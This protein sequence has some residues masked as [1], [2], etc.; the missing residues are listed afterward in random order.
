[1]R[2]GQDVR[3]DAA[4]AHATE[5]LIANG[6]GGSAS[7]TSSG[8]ATRRT[9][10][11]LIS[12][13]EHGRQTTLL[14]ALDERLIDARGAWDLAPG[15]PAPAGAAAHAA[16]RG[17]IEHFT[18]D[19]APTWRLRAGDVVLEKRIQVIHDHHAVIVSYRHLAGGEARLTLGP[20]VV[21]RR[22]S[23]LQREDHEVRGAAQGVPGRVKIEMRP[24]DPTLTLWHNGTFLP[25]RLWRRGLSYPLDPELGKIAAGRAEPLERSEGEPVG[26]ARG[27]RK[28]TSARARRAG[29]G[30]PAQALPERDDARL[31][32]EDAL[33]PGW[34]DGTL[35]PGSPL[36]VVASSEEDLFRRLAAE[37]RLGTPPPRSLAECVAMIE[38][39]NV[40]REDGL[41]LTI[42]AG[43]DFTARQAASAHN[44]PLARR[45]DALVSPADRWAPSL[46]RA[47]DHALTRHAQHRTLI[48]ALP[49]PSPDAG[50]PLRALP[51]LVT[52]RRFDE[53]RDVLG[54]AIDYLDEGLAPEGFDPQDGTPRHADPEPAL[55]LVAAA[56]VYVRRSNDLE[57]LGGALYP[58][59]ES[60]MQFYRSGTR[61]VRVGET[62][63]L[64]IEP[65]GPAVA[66]ADLNA[67]WYHALV[68]MAQLARL[69]SRKESGAFYL[70]WAR[71]LRQRF[72]EQFW[73]ESNGRLFDRLENGAPVSGIR[74]PHVLAASLHP[75]VI[76]PERARSLV[77]ALERDLFT[78][79]GLRERPRGDRV[80]TS[81]LGPYYSA[82]VRAHG[83]DPA[84]LSRVHDWLEMLRDALGEPRFA[85]VPA[86][87]RLSAMLPA[88]PDGIYST[89]A[90]GELLRAWIEEL[91]PSAAPAVREEPAATPA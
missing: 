41:A 65:D 20:C 45:R 7:G 34:I 4:S 12:A 75:L 42:V 21:C 3:A 82:Y 33:V 53:T 1:M 11:L 13:S 46:G 38:R 91:D 85:G 73:D 28:P 18:L 44:S 51:A 10:S 67:L 68:A 6:L 35:A 63:L 55:W 59:L 90:A 14:L 40:R 31:E 17:V 72:G 74:P 15:P 50:H 86:T 87:F 56:D 25:A 8:V 19:P 60:V 16:G 84:A 83:R 58:A 89:A 37:E 49:V 70:A 71:E 2:Q 32:T 64:E 26:A 29:G 5:W 66:R 23:E 43:A 61:G 78:P 39:E 88:R 9:H 27:G 22:P 36:V 57:F 47:L 79:F 48:G 81:W 69:V 52:L 77:D 30:H 80:I 62:G 76:V 24:H 54:G